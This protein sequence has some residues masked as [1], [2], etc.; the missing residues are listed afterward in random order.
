ME[1]DPQRARAR[2]GGERRGPRGDLA[3]R[4]GARARPS[5]R[6]GRL[7]AAVEQ[8]P[9]AIVITDAEGT[10]EYVNPAFCHQS[11][12]SREEA[13][14]QNPRI[15]KSGHH[16]PEFYAAMYAT[17]SGGGEWRGEFLN[18]KKSGELYWE[19]ATLSPIVDETGRPRHYL[20]VK[21]DIT[22]RKAAEETLLRTQEQLVLSQKLEAVGR[23]AG[24]IAHDFNNLLGVII[25]HGEMAALVRPRGPRGAA[26]GRADPRRGAA[27]R[28]A[29]PA[30]PRLLAATGP[31]AAGRWT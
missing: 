21:E 9:V 28:R 1:R 26:E 27:R 14:G 8:S 24:G 7:S 18:R 16:P 29:R 17:I 22:E 15:L 2:R 30:A 13:L 12:Y 20:A 19:S 23:L 31:A 4:H 10:I 3:R 6:S 25:G 11:G 5:G